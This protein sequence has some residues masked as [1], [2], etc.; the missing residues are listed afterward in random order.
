MKLLEQLGNGKI[1]EVVWIYRDGLEIN[2][3]LSSYPWVV[4]LSKVEFMRWL[5][6]RMFRRGFQTCMWPISGFAHAE[7][8]SISYFESYLKKN[9]FFRVCVKGFNGGKCAMLRNSVSEHV[10]HTYFEVCPFWVVI[11]SIR[12]KCW[13]LCVLQKRWSEC[14]GWT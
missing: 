4:S 2:L 3:F 11:L 1:A 14:T 8:F 12:L 9:H 13:Y 10:Y 5:K 7:V 6:C